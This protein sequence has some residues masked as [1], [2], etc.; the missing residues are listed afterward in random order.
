MGIIGSMGD[1]FEAIS[2]NNPFSAAASVA[3]AGKDIF[4]GIVD[5]N[6]DALSFVSGFFKGCVAI[7]KKANKVYI[8]FV[9]PVRGGYNYVGGF[10]ATE[11]DK[12][13]ENLKY[14]FS[15]MIFVPKNL[16]D[17]GIPHIA[18]GKARY[19]EY[20]GND[21]EKLKAA[22]SKDRK[23]TYLAT[24]KDVNLLAKRLEILSVGK[25]LTFQEVVGLTKLYVDLHGECTLDETALTYQCIVDVAVSATK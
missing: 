20:A 8:Y 5:I 4:D 15:H 10:L 6:D 17:Y 25:I 3:S 7:P 11:C 18:S 2:N 24:E 19:E 21:V 9:R 1:F 22:V 13:L 23:H 16:P 12:I 14:D